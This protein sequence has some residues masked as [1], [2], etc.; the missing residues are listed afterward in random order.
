MSKYQRFKDAIEAFQPGGADAP[1]VY[2][3]LEVNEKGFKAL[4]GRKLKLWSRHTNAVITVCI[5]IL[6]AAVIASA[7]MTRQ[8]GG[9]SVPAPVVFTPLFVY[10]LFRPT[11][12][13]ITNAG[14]DVYVLEY[15]FGSK[16]LVSDKLSL[17]FDRLSDVKVKVGKDFK[18]TH[19]AFCFDD[20]GKTRKVKISVSHR[21]RKVQEQEGN[22][23][24]LLEALEREQL[25]RR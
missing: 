20:N 22:L 5:L 7:I 12:L 8:L 2:A 24:I 14:V 9:T 23:K 1:I 6:A 4:A 11:L 21:M 13:T 17:P 15:K 3:T 16:P 10:F 18:N 25:T 19:F